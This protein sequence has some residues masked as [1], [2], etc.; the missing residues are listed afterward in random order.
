MRDR[1]RTLRGAACCR[2]GCCSLAGR[3]A[4]A[5]RPELRSRRSRSLPPIPTTTPTRPSPAS[6][7]AAIRWPRSVIE[8]LQDGRLL[9][10]PDDKKVYIREPAGPL[11]DAA[12]GKPIAGA[13]PAGLKPVRINNRLRR[14]IEAA[15][16]GLTLLVARPGQALRGGAGRVQVEATPTRCPRSM[17]RSA[18]ETDAARQAGAAGGARGRHSRHRRRQGGRQA[19][20]HR[21]HPRPRRSGRARR[22]WRR[23]PPNQ[24]RRRA[25]RRCRRHQGHRRS[26]RRVE[27]GAEPLVRPLAGLGA[28][29]RRHRPCH[30][31]RR[32]GRHQH[33]AWRDGDARR[34]HDLRRAG[35]DPRHGARGCS[36]T[37]W[38][39]PFRWR[40]W[41][42]AWSASPSSAAS[43][44]SSTAGRW[45][46]CSPPGASA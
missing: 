40:S 24:P 33:G 6:P 25:A 12:T 36:T 4:Q 30:H 15:L 27:R 1:L 34:L 17:R 20:G 14:S 3:H 41:S 39:S 46:R 37:R 35:A 21:R 7:P 45:R 11:L 26:A 8:A 44:A 23:C 2:S 18:K 5:Q 22:C 13:A 42:P 19:R 9:F 10:N 16:G 31:L 38:R 29:A 28:A 32:D 43:S